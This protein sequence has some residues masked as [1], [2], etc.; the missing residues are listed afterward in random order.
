[1]IITNTT[2]LLGPTRDAMGYMD[3]ADTCF[4]DRAEIK[5]LQILDTLSH[6]RF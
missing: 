5:F 2:T 6:I 3:T 1:M 4:L